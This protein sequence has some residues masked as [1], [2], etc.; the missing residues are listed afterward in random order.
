MIDSHAH[1]H[2]HQL[3]AEL[4]KV[5][6]RFI[7][8]GG[9]SIINCGIDM[10]S[11][12]IVIEQSAKYDQ[13]IPAVGL[14]PELF[15]P[16]S[17]IYRSCADKKWIDKNIKFLEELLERHKA[18]IVAIGECGL[19]YYWVKDQN[20]PNRKNIF[21]LQKYLFES[22]IKLAHKYNLPMIIHCRDEFGDK[23]CEAEILKLLVQTG[24]SCVPGLFHSYTG[25]LHYLKDILNL[26]FYVSF[27]GIVTYKG[28]NNVRELLASVPDERLLIETDAPYLVPNA[29]RSKGMRTCEP[30][31]IEEVGAY[32]SKSR[33]ISENDLWILVEKNFKALFRF[34]PF[35]DHRVHN[36]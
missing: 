5:I 36:V 17:D 28:A 31:M 9:K 32:I 13:I 27:N 35:S 11:N 21:K 4:D 34:G 8:A 25:S 6:N 33:N 24:K 22:Q 30:F 3:A 20:L 15:V 18:S 26:C 16:G 23:Q 12:Q 7:N 14:H 19:D 1:L 2:S 29:L 10:E